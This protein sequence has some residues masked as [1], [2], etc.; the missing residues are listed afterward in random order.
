MFFL[1]IFIFDLFS[2]IGGV[3]QVIFYLFYGVNFL[4]N[5]YVIAYDTNSLFFAIKDNN[6]IADKDN[7]ANSFEGRRK[8]INKKLFNLKHNIKNLTKAKRSSKYNLYNMYE[9][10]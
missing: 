3:V 5:K 6:A 7:K 10:N 1:C 9:K 2:E 8:S 4:Y